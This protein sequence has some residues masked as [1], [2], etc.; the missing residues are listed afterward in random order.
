MT[1]EKLQDAITLLPNDLVA[2]TDRLRTA[3]GT[4]M[5]RWK[6]W[7][8]M[9]ACLVLL[10]STGLVFRGRILPGMGTKTES[11]AAPM[12]EASRKESAMGAPAA[13]EA[14]PEEAPAEAGMADTTGQS[15]EPEKQAADHHHGFAEEEETD[16]NA[17]YCGNML[18]TIL[19][20]GE[21]YTLSGSDSVAITD[22]LANLYYDPSLI[23]RCMAEFTV[24]T[25]L[26]TGIEVNLEEA[27]ARC[28]RGQAALTEA[29]VQSIREIV[30]NLQ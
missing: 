13:D 7:A 5:I 28:D 30:N 11:A 17:G 25:E 15:A 12:M 24:D 27:F 22:I 21:K 9:A 4:R 1:A 19:L 10:L 8:A 6:Q 29:Q 16:L 14:A 26:L 20:E 18:T 3:P 23:C 2:S